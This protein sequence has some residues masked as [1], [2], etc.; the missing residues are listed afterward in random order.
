[1]D[2]KSGVQAEVNLVLLQMRAPKTKEHKEVRVH[3]YS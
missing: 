1:M 2:G 3:E